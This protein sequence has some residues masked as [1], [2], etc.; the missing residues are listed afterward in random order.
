MRG[1]NASSSA[2]GWDF[3]VN[4]GIVLM[5]MNLRHSQSVR[6][7]GK[8]EDVEITLINGRKIHAQAKSVYDSDDYSHVIDKLNKALTT[9]ANA[10]SMSETERLIYATNSPNPFN[11][12]Q[13]MQAFSG[14]CAYL[15]YTDL[16]K[17]C[18][19]RIDTLC[20]NHKPTLLKDNLHV[21]VF[22]FRG[23]GENRYRVVRDKTNELLAQ[24][25]L[26]DRGWG[27]QTLD[28]W[29]REFRC[30]S[31]QHNLSLKITKKQMLWPL[32]VW[33]CEVGD[34]DARFDDCDEADVNEILSR[35][36]TVICDNA[37]RFE[38]ITKVMTAY[39]G[40][41]TG[42]PSKTRTNRFVSENWYN[43]IGEFALPNTDE[44]IAEMVV[45]IAVHNV[46]KSRH[47]IASVKKAV[48]L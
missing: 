45:K 40:F 43:F 29:H 19:D 34:D 37:E 41:E 2:F 35:Y 47:Q 16:P 13:S 4:A 24:L 9:L 11:D 20:D 44:S 21:L 28:V 38:F 17:V 5:L 8:T 6:I 32:I 27:K 22:D 30:N 15:P 25:N 10:Q 31:S 33:L 42:L 14:S 39:S 1:T 26:S 3:Q 48:N 36:K 46:I 18:K 23:D 7:E 12:V